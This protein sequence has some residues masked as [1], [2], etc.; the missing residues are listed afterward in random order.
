MLQKK[1]GYEI[2]PIKTVVVTGGHDFEET[3][4]FEMF[5]FVELVLIGP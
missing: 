3:E 4:F 1:N 5:Q 2:G